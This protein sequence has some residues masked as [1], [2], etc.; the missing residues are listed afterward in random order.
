M[1][2]QKSNT[3]S[4]K[5]NTIDK[6]TLIY[7]SGLRSMISDSKEYGIGNFKQN[8]KMNQALEF[9]IVYL[10]AWLDYIQLYSEE[11]ITATEAII[12]IDNWLY[13]AIKKLDIIN[14]EMIIDPLGRN[15]IFH[16]VEN[17]SHLM[18][19]EDYW[20]ITGICYTNSDFAFEDS[21]YIGSFLLAERS[22]REFLMNEDERIF[23]NTLPKNIRI[24]R[25]CSIQEIKSGKFRFSWTLNKDVA[26][27][28]AHK[29]SRNSLI[30]SEVV[31]KT[32]SKSKLIAYFNDRDEE[33]VLYIG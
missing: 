4:S 31:Q 7:Y 20:M 8:I 12:G 26:D 23:F 3:N 16:L 24:Y 28:F 13:E 30:K 22:K 15:E 33:E 9:N 32:V 6:K 5:I 1:N 27:F 19:D 2:P 18:S 25:G 11:K 14:W 10:P 17:L 21:G 29:Y